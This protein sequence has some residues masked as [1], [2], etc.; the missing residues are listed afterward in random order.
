MGVHL[1]EEKLGLR[2]SLMTDILQLGVQAVQD[3]VRILRGGPVKLEMTE[4]DDDD[5]E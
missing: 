5:D 1:I 4:D 2:V 3:A